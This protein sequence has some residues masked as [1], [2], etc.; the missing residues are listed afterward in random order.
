MPLRI[1]GVDDPT[2]LL[3]VSF[4]CKAIVF[5]RIEIY[6]DCLCDV[7]DRIERVNVAL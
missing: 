3:G 6:V 7:S 1:N 2:R 4:Q 5:R